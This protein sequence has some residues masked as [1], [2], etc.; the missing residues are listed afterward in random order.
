M[1]SP[2]AG[3]ASI[4]RLDRRALHRLLAVTV[5]GFASGLP[6]ALT[7]QAMQAW[8]TADGVDIATIGFLS[9]VGLPYT[10]KFLW[11]PLMDRFEP[12]W[13]GR[14]RGWL[15]VSQ[16]AL[17]A[18]L[19]WMAA[20]P[21]R[22]GARRV[23][24]SRR[25]RR[26]AVGIAGR[27]RRRYRTDLLPAA[28]RGFG[29]SLTVLGYRLAMIVSG[30]IAFIWVDPRQGGGWTWPEVY[31]AMALFMVGAAVFSALLAPRLVA[32]G[33]AVE[34]RAQ[35]RARLSSPSRRGRGR[36]HRHAL[37]V[38]AVV[39]RRWSRRCLQDT[40]SP[41]RCRTLG[42]PRRAV[43]R[44]RADRAAGRVGGAAGA[45]RD[46]PRQPGEL[47]RA[48]RRAAVPRLH[49][50]LQARRRVRRI[51]ADAVP[52]P[53]DAL[54]HR[55]GRRRQQ[56]DRP[57]AD[58]RRRAARR[59]AHDPARP[60][61]IA[62]VLR[63]AADARQPRLLVARAARPRRAAGLVLPRSTGASSSS[64]SRRRSTAAS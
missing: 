6:L 27:R 25:A 10:F 22:V 14:R 62:D 57:L 15:V 43:R 20:T 7:G 33:E 3:G 50:P 38:R 54:Q 42:R 36:L 13:L 24:P 45:L 26:V 28:E 9:L 58:D 48:A 52:A 21:P 1:T 16:L 12:P 46:L 39:A 32:A 31:R 51:A 35:R 29:S 17:A 30:G 61:A 40:A 8:L 41:H 4:A 11:A 56:G 19:F 60:V 47:L 18:A 44:H 53:G 23:R 37:R 63:R 64:P 49:R 34:R 2:P 55:R 59:R 5:L